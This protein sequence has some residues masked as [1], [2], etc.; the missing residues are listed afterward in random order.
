[1]PLRRRGTLARR[2]PGRRVIVPPKRHV[3]FETLVE[4]ALDE[5]PEQFGRLLADV[6]I[7]IEEAPSPEQ[8][9]LGGSPDDDWLYGLYEGVPSVEWG[10]DMVPMPRKITLFRLPLEADFP[11]PDDLA[12]EVRITV[13]HE[14]GHH[15]GLDEDRL[16]AL[17]YD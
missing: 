10:A 14:L 17:D 7:V 2:H 8:V 4:R 6:A 15:A 13:M 1:M 9:R 16:R 11:D 3:P 5:L 12:E